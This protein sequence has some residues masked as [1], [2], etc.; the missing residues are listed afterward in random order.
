MPITPEILAIMDQYTLACRNLLQRLDRLSL[1]TQEMDEEDLTYDGCLKD[2]NLILR[3]F[4]KVC[5]GRSPEPPVE[6]LKRKLGGRAQDVRHHSHL[7]GI[8]DEIIAGLDGQAS[9]WSYRED[10]EHWH[11]QGRILAGRFFDDGH[12]AAT[13]RNPEI[14]C[15]WDLDYDCYKTAAPAAYLP[16][17]NKLIVSFHFDHGFNHYLTYPIFFLHEYTAHVYALDNGKNK[18]FNDGW[19]LYAAC[20]F[21]AAEWQRTLATGG[22]FPLHEAQIRLAPDYIPNGMVRP[23]ERRGYELAEKI[24]HL[25]QNSEACLRNISLG[26]SGFQPLQGEGEEWP[27]VFL[28]S[29]ERDLIRRKDDPEGLKNLID[30]LRTAPDVREMKKSFLPFPWEK[31]I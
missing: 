4:F 29:L 19:M 12:W 18:M 2:F 16:V 22:R 30:T 10:L 23:F 3:E 7:A 28:K 17:T 8:Y 20:Q 26:L 21:L 25:F 14:K 11:E 15:E 6:V 24:H 31:Y 9:F 5:S 13:R 27:K 1:A